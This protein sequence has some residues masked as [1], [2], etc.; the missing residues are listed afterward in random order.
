MLR[1]VSQKGDKM[2]LHKL[3]VKNKY[4]DQAGAGSNTEILIDGQPV[5]GCKSLTFKVAAGGLALVT[6][7]FFANIDMES[8]Q[9]A[10]IERVKNET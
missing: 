6:L 9:I 10:K 2:S 7:E 4:D 1:E 8:Y 5:K 3:T